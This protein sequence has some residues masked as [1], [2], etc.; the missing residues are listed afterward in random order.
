MSAPD[1]CGGFEDLEELLR[2]GDPAPLC[3]MPRWDSPTG[4]RILEQVVAR[5][6]T[7]LTWRRRLVPLGAIRRRLMS[8]R[9]DVV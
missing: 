2:R 8:T 6:D 5:S 3:E 4:I 9:R 7:P 1:D